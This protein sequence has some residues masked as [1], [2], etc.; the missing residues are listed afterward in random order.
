MKN[1][2][3]ILNVILIIAVGVLYYLHFNSSTGSPDPVLNQD[4][5]ANNAAVQN[6]KIAYVNQDSLLRSYSFFEDVQALLAEKQK[7]LE[8]NFGSKQS[9]FQRKAADFQ[10]KVAKQLVT[11]KQA[12]EMQK[13]LMEEEQTLVQLRDRMAMQLRNDEMTMTMQINDSIMSFLKDY[14]KVNNFIYVLN[15]AGGIM[16]A[17]TTLDITSVVIK[18]LNS[19]T[20]N[21][22][23]KT[24]S[25][26][27]VST[28]ILK[29]IS[30]GTI[31]FCGN[32]ISLRASANPKP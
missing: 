1:I 17:D 27:P 4:T 7:S 18:G 15:S 30:A 16:Y 6:I 23:A 29:K 21:N 3:L 12:E 26:C 8:G 2:S 22:T 9:A 31:S 5:A 20:N 11:R 19:Q 25:N 13:Q 14:N 32:P 10:E 24:N 28:P